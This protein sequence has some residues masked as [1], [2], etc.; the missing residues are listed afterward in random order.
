V[1]IQ[2]DLGTDARDAYLFVGWTNKST[3]LEAQQSGQTVKFKPRQLGAGSICSK[4]WAAN[5]LAY[6]KWSDREDVLAFSLKYQVPSNQT[7]LLAVP[8]SEM[9]LFRQKKDEY[10]RNLA[11]VQG[12]GKRRRR[13]RRQDLNW[14]QNR[15]GDPE[16]RI[17]APDAR[18][19]FARLPDGRVLQLR[20]LADGLWGR[21]FDVPADATEGTYQ[22]TVTVVRRDGTTREQ[23]VSYN[24]DRTKPQGTAEL[25]VEQGKLVLRVRA[26]PKLNEV[27]AFLADGRKIVLK[28]VSPGVYEVVLSGDPSSFSGE[29]VVV[30][31]DGASNKTE[32]RCTW[33]LR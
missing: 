10:L 9:K 2:R 21:N 5:Y 29:I 33:P 16:L 27:A 31:K 15:G 24:V 30:L 26:E 14:N 13:G 6:S 7:A 17:L 23:A 25:V 3:E 12:E 4:L 20:P 11:R 1:V 18:S 32:L 22:I 19:V 28:E 8:K